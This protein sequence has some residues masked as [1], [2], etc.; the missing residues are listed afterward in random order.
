MTLPLAPD[1]QHALSFLDMLRPVGRHTIASEAPFGSKEGGPLWERGN[2]FEADE[3]AALIKDI[4]ARQARG[5][6]V[7]YSVN[8]P[9]PKDVRIGERQE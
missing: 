8:E 4:V 7:Y 5:S 9:C 2:T 3:T 6:N 1:I